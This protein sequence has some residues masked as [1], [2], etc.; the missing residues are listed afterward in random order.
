MLPKRIRSKITW[1][2]VIVI[3]F[4]MTENRKVAKAKICLESAVK[5]RKLSVSQLLYL[6][7]AWNFQNWVFLMVV[8]STENFKIF[9]IKEAEI[10]GLL[11]SWSYQHQHLDYPH[12][13]IQSM[14]MCNLRAEL[15]QLVES[16]LFHF[17]FFK[18]FSWWEKEHFQSVIR[19]KDYH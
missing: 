3:F 4:S 13:S 10:K 16:N 8:I 14:S 19:D 6:L 15:L 18:V 5:T 11:W 12:Q 7:P 2:L 1:P 9:D 17:L